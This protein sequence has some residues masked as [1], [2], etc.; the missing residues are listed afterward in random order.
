MYLESGAP[1]AVKIA[2]VASSKMYLI[3]YQDFWKRVTMRQSKERKRVSK[4]KYSNMW[5][6]S[7]VKNLYFHF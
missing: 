7:N 2:Q 1:D 5:S 3:L 6:W 4:S